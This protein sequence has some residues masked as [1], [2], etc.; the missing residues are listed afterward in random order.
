MKIITKPT[1]QIQIHPEAI[2]LFNSYK[3]LFKKYPD[4][5]VKG[6]IARETL[7][8]ICKKEKGYN[9]R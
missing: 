4:L 6:G 5:W 1:S 2:K 9:I 3:D 7:I 8:G